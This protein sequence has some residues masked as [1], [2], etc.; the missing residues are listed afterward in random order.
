MF[1]TRTAMPTVHIFLVA[2]SFGTDDIPGIGDTI[3][4]QAFASKP[5][6]MLLSDGSG[7]LRVPLG[8]T[9]SP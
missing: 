2:A 3:C 6:F 5:A 1:M 7:P 4:E 8:P 9:L